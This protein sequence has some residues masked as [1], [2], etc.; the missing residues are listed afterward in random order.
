MPET[1][2]QLLPHLVV[3]RLSG[4]IGTKSR[5]TQARFRAR[6]MRNLKDA[7]RAEEL[8]AHIVRTH[9]RIFVETSEAR[10]TA[11]L[12]RVFGIQSI[13][14]AV[15]RPVTTLDDVV[16]AGFEI[17]RDRVKGKRFA[18]RAR[19]VGDRTPSSLSS[20]EVECALGRRL[21]PLSAGVNL[22]APEVTAFVELCSGEAYFF[23]ER[24]AGPA[25][26]PLGV[27]GRAVALVSGGFDSAV[28]A[29]LVQKRGVALDHVFCNLGGGAHEAG[30]LRVMKT[31]ADRWSYG[32]APR[33]H[34]IDFRPLA[35]QLQ[36]RTQP[37]YWQVLLKR[38]MLRAAEAV[39]KERGAA[40]LVTGEAL[41][42]VSS[43]T[44]ANLAVI[45]PAAALPVLRPVI[46]MNKDEILAIARAIGTYELSAVVGEYCALV[47]GRPATEAR[48]AAVLGEEAKL[49]L[50]WLANA[51]IARKIF[52]LRSLD[53]ESVALGPAELELDAIPEDAVVIDLRSRAAYQSW[54]WPGALWLDFAHAAA[55][56]PKF[57]SQRNYLVYCEF[58]LKSAHLAELMR[59]SG[60][61]AHNFRGGLRRLVRHAETRG[62]AGP[63]LP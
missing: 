18:V 56:Y 20:R 19:R 14:P 55:A 41:G 50:T 45:T 30:V 27:E 52:H 31:L 35:E 23:P 38:L 6:L 26:L 61:R 15:R 33:L 40:A 60:L 32:S 58:G 42:Q 57:D 54:H 36:A 16:D 10:A 8:R 37:R 59:K 44:L 2:R 43:Q 51:V 3:L 25:G 4:D 39:A 7:M 49:D 22:D 5:P 11:V 1:T 34:A 47:P 12:A 28:A 53:L 13:S 46:G 21:L 17:F 29:W 9:N 63:Q 62:I 24:V 48:L